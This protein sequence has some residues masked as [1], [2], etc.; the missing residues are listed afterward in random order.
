MSE[1]SEAQQT[2]FQRLSAIEAEKLAAL[3]G[4]SEAQ[5]RELR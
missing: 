1:L 5:R 2:Y 3:N 4:P